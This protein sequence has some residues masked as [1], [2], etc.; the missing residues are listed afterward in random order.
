MHQDSKLSTFIENPN[1]SLWKLTIPMMNGLFVNSI[2]I[3]VDTYFLGTKIGTSAIS[4]LGYVMPFYFIIMGITFGL[5]AGTTTMIAQYIGKKDKSR[6]EL[7][8]QNSLLMAFSLSIINFMSSGVS[9]GGS[10][11]GIKQTVVYPPYNAER[12]PL[13]RVSLPSKPKTARFSKSSG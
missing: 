4:A 1:I 2:Y 9:I 8:A 3:L 11:F 10:V 7:V 5:A 13:S 6:A 12:H